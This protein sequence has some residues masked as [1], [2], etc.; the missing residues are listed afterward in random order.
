[1]IPENLLPVA[2]TIWESMRPLLGEYSEV[3]FDHILTRPRYAH[4]RQRL[5]HVVIQAI[6]AAANVGPPV[7]GL[8]DAGPKTRTH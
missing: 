4:V 8:P 5:A 2:R 7:Q 3:P 6:N 1:M